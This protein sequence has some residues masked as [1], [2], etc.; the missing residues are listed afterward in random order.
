MILYSASKSE[1]S[2]DIISNQIEHRLLDAF[3]KRLG[4]RT[5]KSEIDSWKNSF[6]YIHNLLIDPEIPD[7]VTV[8]LEYKV[9]HTAKR[10]DLL[11]CGKNAE[12]RNSVVIIELKQWSEANKTELDGIVETR[13][14]G[15]LRQT[16]H[17]AYQAWTYASMLKDF[18]STVQDKN[19]EITSC[20]YLHNCEGSA[21][22]LDDF[23]KE[24]IAK[25]PVFMRKDALKLQAFIK[26]H[27]R[28]GD[29]DAILYQ[30]DNGKIRPSKNL[31][32]SLESMLKGNEEF[33]MIDDQKLVAESVIYSSKSAT[34]KNKKVF[35]IEG[36]PGSGKSVVAINLLVMLTKLGQTVKYVT[37]NAAPR[38]VYEQLLTKSFKKSY[39]SNLFT[40]SGA[41]TETEGNTFDTLIVDEAHRLNEKSGLYSNLG[42]NQ[43]KEIIGSALTSVF[44]LD[45]NQKV[46]LKDIGTR[47]EIEKWA[48]KESASITHLKLSSQFRCNGSDAYMAWLNS[49]LQVEKTDAGSLPPHEFEF[50]IFDSPSGLRDE[51]WKRN[52][53]RNKARL[54]AGYCWPW[55]SKTNPGAFDV[56]IGQHFKMKWNLT[57]DGSAWIIQP[58]S[59]EQVGCIHT[60]QGLEVDYVGVI[61]GPD[62]IV[63]D[64]QVVTDGTKRAK[65]DQSIKG[66]K[67]WL[68]SNPEEANAEVDLIIKNTYRT[69]MTRGA[70][71]CFI[72]SEDPET[73]DHFRKVLEL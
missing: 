71:G 38:A 22:L 6:N 46:T 3:E 8:A 28:Y 57:V 61:L 47:D 66:F 44:F 56:V 16:A 49:A 51:I 43:V 15:A 4:R 7:D 72:Y 54:V 67:A 18:N 1:F 63:R 21:D 45:E 39:I 14:G 19:I 73:R 5:G 37:K 35:I 50:R 30:I 32:D 41:F 60:C 29:Q 42:E 33:L 40:G 70:K 12:K 31:A 69:L 65:S 52:Q 2:K 24:H 64:G 11:I 48:K 23:Y 25:A 26:K 58:N 27:V 9:P 34:A 62:L 20:A 53:E 59:S 55:N 17:P 68:K 13:L 36:G 10:I